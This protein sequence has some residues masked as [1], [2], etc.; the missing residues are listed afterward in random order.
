MRDVFEIMQVSFIAVCSLAGVLGSVKY[1][2]CSHI[3]KTDRV[4]RQN[5]ER[6]YIEKATS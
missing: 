2:E 1:I 5:I 3:K 6:V 4:M